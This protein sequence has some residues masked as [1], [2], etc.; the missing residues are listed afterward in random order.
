M[1]L[2]SLP[3]KLN[4]KTAVR[5]IVALAALCTFC[6]WPIPSFGA[7]IVL[8][9]SVDIPTAVVLLG[10]VAE[11][12]DADE[13]L[14]KRLAAVTLFP[15]PAAGRSKAVDFDSVR[16]RLVSQGFNMTELEFSGSSRLTVRGVQSGEGLE[17][18][19]TAAATEL[20]QKRADEMVASG[21]RLYLNEKARSLGNIQVE[22]KL[23]P[24]QVSL[25]T[26]SAS[27][28]VEI[29]GGGEPWTGNQTF[30]A[31]F[32]DRPG[33]PVALLIECRV[34]P[35]AQALVDEANLPKARAVSSVNASR[36][37]QQTANSEGTVLDR[38]KLVMGLETKHSLR[39]G[40]P[41]ILT[42]IRGLPLVH[43]GDIVTV[44]AR[45]RGIVVRTDAKALAD[46][47]LGQP[48]KLASLDKRRE[49]SGWVSGYHEVAMVPSSGKGPVASGNGTGIQLLKAETGYQPV[50]AR[51]TEKPL[52]Q[53]AQ[54]HGVD[55][56]HHA[57]DSN[58]NK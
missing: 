25:L 52:G 1:N 31:R 7:M 38:K 16:R 11:I 5:R 57:V 55:P 26:A 49:L 21:V 37:Q 48:I 33:H 56:L 51:V 9:D 43:C 6:D 8:K 27:D 36:T 34:T 17:D 14:V 10:Q 46:G 12:H 15:T 35:L 47:S 30:R 22:L 44:T 42:D 41:I 50:R 29:S 4:K 28:R 2:L 58:E 18:E 20:S 19:A 32:Y 45:S 24:K 53:P 54:S 40:E 23:T 39:T 3:F 13:A